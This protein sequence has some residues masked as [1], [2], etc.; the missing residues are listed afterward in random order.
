MANTYTSL[1]FHTIFST[2]NNERWITRKNE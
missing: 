1:H 2:K